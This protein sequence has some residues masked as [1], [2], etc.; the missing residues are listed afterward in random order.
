MNLDLTGLHDQYDYYAANQPK[1]ASFA[2]ETTVSQDFSVTKK[3]SA[4]VEAIYQSPTYFVINHYRYNYFFNTGLRYAVAKNA[5]LN[6]T[7]SDIFN[8]DVDRLHSN[9]LNLDITQRDKRA[10]RFIGLS[11]SYHFGTSSV[12]NRTNTTDEQKRLGGSSNEN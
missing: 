5:S 12:R 4:Q 9:Y 10:T 6:L 1:G 3:L 2:L 8:T 11:F 7:V